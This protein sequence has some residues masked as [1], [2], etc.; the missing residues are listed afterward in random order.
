MTRYIITGQDGLIGK[1]LV[2]RLDEQNWEQVLNI[3]M[4]SGKNVNDFV[5]E[6]P[7]E[8]DVLFHLAAQCKINESIDNPILPFYHNVQG[9]FNILEF[10]RINDIKKIVYFSSSRVISEE[11]NPYTASKI[12]GEELCKAYHECYGIEYIIIRPSTV[13]SIGEDK[14]NRLINIWI[15]A[16]KRSEPLKI[17][18]PED[19]TLSF[20]Y[21]DDFLDA[22]FLV[23][24]NAKWNTDY[25]VHGI[26][27]ELYIVAQE[28][29]R[30]TNS[31]SKIEF[32]NAEFAQP[33]Y[34]DFAEMRLANLGY[35]PKY[36]I[37]QGLAKCL[38]KQ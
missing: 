29:I 30:L 10:C 12:Y 16:A 34:V 20:T 36:T 14:T 26:E 4:R 2:K 31:K 37:K 21:I 5:Y 19:K 15:N 9:I 24:D 8:C 11:K 6:D 23:L 28:I 32:H 38:K 33:Q 7:I 27:E 3:D 18:G 35:K 13:Y 1:E 22:L 25:S 17:Y